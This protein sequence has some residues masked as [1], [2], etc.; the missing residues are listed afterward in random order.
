MD[1]RFAA[2]AT[3]PSSALVQPPHRTAELSNAAFLPMTPTSASQLHPVLATVGASA[4]AWNAYAALIAAAE[5]LALAPQGMRGDG[6]LSQI[7]CGMDWV[8][9]DMCIYI[10]I[11]FLFL[12]T[13]HEFN[14]HRDRT[15]Q[16]T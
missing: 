15:D 9:F 2:V 6:N 10:Y 4:V 14:E 11:F 1:L 12:H 7:G 13:M 3:V 8:I 16:Q 5:A